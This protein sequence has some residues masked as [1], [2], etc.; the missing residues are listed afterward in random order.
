MILQRLLKINSIHNTWVKLQLTKYNT[1]NAL[2]LWSLIIILESVI[3]MIHASIW[4][5]LAK[6]CGL[7][8][9]KYFHIVASDV[10]PIE[11]IF[12]SRQKFNKK[13]MLNL[14]YNHHQQNNTNCGLFFQ[15]TRNYG[16][17]FKGYDT[18]ISIMDA[19]QLSYLHQGPKFD[20][21]CVQ[22]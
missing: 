11:N 17:K 7:D 12:S 19:C 14:T 8:V 18:F 2:C 3:P 13:F 1:R 6:N 5:F 4:I 20:K 9:P 22:K 15:S 10:N 16:E 21:K